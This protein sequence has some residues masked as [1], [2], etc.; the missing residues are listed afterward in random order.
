MSSVSWRSIFKNLQGSISLDFILR[1][2]KKDLQVILFILLISFTNISYAQ[3]YTDISSDSRIENALS[4]LEKTDSQK[5]LNTLMGS[6]SSHHPVK[7]IFYSLMLLDPKLADAHALSTSANDG[8]IYIVIDSKYQ[9]EPR[10]ALASIIVHEA[11]H[12]LSRTTME[13]EIQAWT[14]EAVQWIKFKKMNPK[15]AHLDENQYRLVKRLNYLESLYLKGNN[16]NELIAEAVINNSS[17]QLL[18]LK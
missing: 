13:E 4:V 5:V 15:L 10:E 9:N 12:Q 8:T 1:Y 16:T 3:K 2:S 17:Y 6:N 11:T 7:I 14:N 18:S